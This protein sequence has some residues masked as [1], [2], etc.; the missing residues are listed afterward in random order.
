MAETQAF[1]PGTVKFVLMF[2]AAF[3]VAVW[4][5]WTTTRRQRE[6]EREA[7]QRRGAQSDKRSNDARDRRDGPAP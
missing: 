5:I 1:D 3:V 7:E 6:F 4:G 2:G